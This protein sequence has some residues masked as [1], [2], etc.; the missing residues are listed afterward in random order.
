MYFPANQCT[1]LGQPGP[2]VLV[3]HGVS[4]GAPEHHSG[5][6]RTCQRTIKCTAHQLLHFGTLDSAPQHTIKCTA[7]VGTPVGARRRTLE[8]TTCAPSAPSAH[9][10]TPSVHHLGP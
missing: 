4:H 10:G 8:C 3:S 5:I 1:C 9:I 6:Q 7:H 2:D